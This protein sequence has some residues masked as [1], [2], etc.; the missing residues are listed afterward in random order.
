MS[1]FASE[2]FIGTSYGFLKNGPSYVLST[3]QDPIFRGHMGPPHWNLSWSST[4]TFQFMWRGVT[5]VSMN[6]HFNNDKDKCGET[7]DSE[8]IIIFANTSF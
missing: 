3:T 8:I 2:L 6:E 1:K 4:F 7:T 5:I